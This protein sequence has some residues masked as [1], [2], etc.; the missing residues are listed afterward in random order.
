MI[1]AQ[2]SVE[3]LRHPDFWDNFLIINHHVV[4]DGDREFHVACH[5][6]TISWSDRS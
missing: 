1:S 3:E 4:F 2:S 5:V 6:G